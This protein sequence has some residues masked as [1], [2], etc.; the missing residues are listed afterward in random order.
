MVEHVVCND[1]IRVR[2]PM[3]PCKLSLKRRFEQRITFPRKV[4]SKSKNSQI[5]LKINQRKKLINNNKNEII[6]SNLT[7]S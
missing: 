7:S 1:E 2:F 3:G 6:R 5:I 4:K